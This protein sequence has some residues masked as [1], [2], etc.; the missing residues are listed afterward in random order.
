MSENPFGV[1]MIVK[2]CEDH[3]EKTVDSLPHQVIS[4][5]VIVDTGST[6]KTPAALHEGGGTIRGPR[7]A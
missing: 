2:N 4:E 3:L 1:G 6:D 5:V 7:A